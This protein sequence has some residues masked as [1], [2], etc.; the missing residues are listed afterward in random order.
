MFAEV[1]EASKHC[2]QLAIYNVSENVKITEKASIRD[3][4][5]NDSL[6]IFKLD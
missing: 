6:S 2:A 3:F 4:V 1:K 5:R